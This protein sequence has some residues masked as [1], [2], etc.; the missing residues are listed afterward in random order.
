MKH[1]QLVLVALLIIGVTYCSKNKVSQNGSKVK[2]NQ[3]KNKLNVKHSLFR[4]KDDLE[5]MSVEYT[6]IPE[7]INQ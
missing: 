2:E 3:Y 1:I 5:R 6:G 7:F 4:E